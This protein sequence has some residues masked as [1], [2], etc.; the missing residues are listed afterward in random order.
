VRSRT[1]PHP[2]YS[3]ATELPENPLEV[4]ASCTGAEH[5]LLQPNVHNKY[6]VL[7][8]GAQPTKVSSWKSAEECWRDPMSR[9][10]ATVLQA[11]T[12]ALTRSS[13]QLPWSVC[14]SILTWSQCNSR[15]FL[16]N[17]HLSLC[18]HQQ[19]AYGEQLSNRE[20]LLGLSSSLQRSQGMEHSVAC[21]QQW[22]DPPTH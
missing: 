15:C 14:D 9:S 1:L 19:K 21:Y 17:P 5:Q 12:K 4:C 11:G 10:V 13:C 3:E 6:N 18:D 8:V 16:P 20:N 22:A 2:K 7:K